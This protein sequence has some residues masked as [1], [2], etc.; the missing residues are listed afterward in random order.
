MNVAMYN[1][2]SLSQHLSKLP[3][4][5]KTYS[6]L[7][8]VRDQRVH[9]KAYELEGRA[10]LSQ[11]CLASPVEEPEVD[12]KV[13]DAFG[14]PVLKPRVPEK[15]ILGTAQV[16]LKDHKNV[17]LGSFKPLGEDDL[18]L[19]RPTKKAN[20]R[21]RSGSTVTAIRSVPKSSQ[22]DQTSNKL[23]LTTPSCDINIEDEQARRT[24]MSSRRVYFVDSHIG[25]RE[26]RDRKRAKRTMISQT[27]SSDVENKTASDTRVTRKAKNNNT[28]AKI[29][30]GFALM[31]G[32]TATN[33]G[34]SRL[35]VRSNLC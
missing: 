9:A 14:T 26:R 17:I 13:Q 2:P 19:D 11:S 31:H 1:H 12:F 27:M 23:P 25:L 3:K 30:A 35:T 29:P 5:D 22:Q 34:A 20:K 4:L 7:T 6:V 33:V 16:P 24:S 21:K 18:R 8:F 28:R 32:F 10:V 15:T